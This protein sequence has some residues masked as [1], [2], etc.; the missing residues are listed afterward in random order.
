[1]QED[2]DDNKALITDDNDELNVSANRLITS[3]CLAL[4]IK[5]RLIR[6]F[7]MLS[8]KRR[9]RRDGENF[10]ILR[11]AIWQIFCK[12]A[13]RKYKIRGHLT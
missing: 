1:M 8:R 5:F 10:S 13:K 4:F 12:T 11:Q 7:S 6:Q 2:N 9:R 3:P